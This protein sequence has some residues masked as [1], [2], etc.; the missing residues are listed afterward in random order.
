MIRM[1]KYSEM[2]LKSYLYHLNNF[3]DFKNKV[4]VKNLSSQDIND[5][6]VNLNEKYVSDSYFNQAINAIR[7]LFVYV[8]NKKIK[9]YLVVRPKKAKTNPIILDANEVQAMFDNCTNTKH[10]A[11]LALLY[12]TGMRGSEII[13]LELNDIEWNSN[14]I[15]IR[16]GKGRKDRLVPLDCTEALKDYIGEY[17]PV[18]WV[19]NGQYSTASSPTQYTKR[20]I[21]EW[22]KQLAFKSGIDKRVYPH[23]IR[24]TK[25]THS[26]E[27][28]T[29]IHSEQILSGHS[30]IKTTIGYT[31]KSPKYISSIPTPFQ[32]IKRTALIK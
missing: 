14:I 11:I 3:L 25:I 23:L 4:S 13:N 8:L 7:F 16:S 22:L 21:Q 18:K 29:D 20:S 2:T 5:Y 30:S 9:D 28:G 19:F 1:K 26:I 32:N 6:L 24:H 27:G 12:S 17:A 31:H 10:F 15:R